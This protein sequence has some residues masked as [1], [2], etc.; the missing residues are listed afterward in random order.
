MAAWPCGG[1][2]RGG[3]GDEPR[4]RD[5]GGGQIVQPCGVMVAGGVRAMAA[6]SAITT[7]V[8]REFLDLASDHWTCAWPL[9][10]LE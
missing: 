5:D 7:A 9:A 1:R 6:T 3:R 8:R 10:P 4:A 2:G